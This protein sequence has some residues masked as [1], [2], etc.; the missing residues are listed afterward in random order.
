ST[1]AEGLNIVLP[2]VA[3]G[4]GIVTSVAGPMVDLF[5]RIPTPVLAAIAAF[6]AMN[7]AMKTFRPVADAAAA[8]AQRLFGELRNITERMAVQQALA[9]MEGETSRFAGTM[10]VATIGAQKL[11]GALKAAVISNPI[12]LALTGISIAVAAVSAALAASAEEAK[13]FE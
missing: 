10:G 2:L 12:G 4:I 6:V 13:A 8:G 7:S 3:D 5:T 1:L 9:G 11:G